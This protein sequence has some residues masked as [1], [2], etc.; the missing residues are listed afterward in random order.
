M[1]VSETRTKFLSVGKIPLERPRSRWEG[2]RSDRRE[3]GWEG[4]DWSHLTND[5]DQ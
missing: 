3:M 2:I 1:T 5:R 4:V